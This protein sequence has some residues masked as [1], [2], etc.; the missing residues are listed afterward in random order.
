MY[1]SVILILT[2]LIRTFLFF[3]YYKLHILNTYI[4]NRNSNVL[5]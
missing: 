1:D 4:L 3:M 2:N 5:L